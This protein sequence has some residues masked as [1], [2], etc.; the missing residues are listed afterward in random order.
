MG[1]RCVRKVVVTALL[2]GCLGLF[3]KPA[4]AYYWV[5]NLTYEGGE[6]DALWGHVGT[7]R[8]WYDP[9]NGS[10]Y[11]YQCECYIFWTTYITT[12]GQLYRPSGSVAAAGIDEDVFLAGLWLNDFPPDETGTWN[13][14]GSHYVTQHV[15]DPGGYYCGY[16]TP[17]EQFWTTSAFSSTQAVV[18]GCGDERDTIIGEYATHG[19]GFTPFCEAFSTAGGSEHFSWGEWTTS[20]FHQPWA[21]AAPDIFVHLEDTR[22]NYDRGALSITSGYRCPHK[23]ALIGGAPNSRHQ[24]GDAADLVPL[25]QS[26]SYDEWVLLGSAAQQAGATF[27]EPWGSGPGQTDDHV[28]A[29]WR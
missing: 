26:W 12:I 17:C 24:Y 22:A 25:E 8:D 2:V 23:N 18:S 19:V 5:N 7:Y 1:D 29:D 15:W 14:H 9:V 20:G 21:I 4:E 10:W 3:A 11:D 16:W 28:H 27:I 13:Q 6:D